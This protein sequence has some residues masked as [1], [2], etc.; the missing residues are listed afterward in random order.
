MAV[1]NV[2]ELLSLSQVSSKIG[3]AFSAGQ[4][5][6]PVE[7][8]EVELKVNALANQLKQLAEAIHPEA[9]NS[10]SEQASEHAR[11][12]IRLILD[13]C[14]LTINNLDS[15]VDHNQVIKKHRTVGGFAIERSWSDLVLAEY[16]TMTWT[17]EGGDLHSLKDRLQMH[18]SSIML[19]TQA[20][21]RQKSL[22]ITKLNL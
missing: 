6:A 5:S 11:Q 10:L 14:K 20:L 21:E 16:A 19:L 9:D 3:R 4:K 17:A 15:L 13:S 8:R 2:G 12:C 22:H 1:P 7:F 18:T